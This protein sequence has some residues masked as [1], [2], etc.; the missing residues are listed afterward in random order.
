MYININ[1]YIIIHNTHINREKELIL[2][3]TFIKFIF[4]NSSFTDINLI[5]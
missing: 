5:T 2:I 1:I 4:K 3:L